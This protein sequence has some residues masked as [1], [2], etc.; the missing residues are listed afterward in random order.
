MLKQIKIQQQK[1]HKPGD[2]VT[3]TGNQN[4]RQPTASELRAKATFEAV[5]VNNPELEGEAAILKEAFEQF[6]K[7]NITKKG[8]EK[9]DDALDGAD[10]VVNKSGTE[11]TIVDSDGHSTNLGAP[12]AKKGKPR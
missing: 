10:I 7:G 2:G 3:K 9:I 11:A 1:Q 12:A 6:L 8:L 5:K 4:G